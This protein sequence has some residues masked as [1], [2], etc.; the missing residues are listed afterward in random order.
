[1]LTTDV[2]V[3]ADASSVLT[4]HMEI[5]AGNDAGAL[6]IGQT[7]IP[8][9]SAA[10][11][12]AVVEAHTLKPDGKTLPV[13][14]T[15]IYDQ[16]LPGQSAG[17]ITGLR[18]KLIVFPQFA[19]GDTA[20]YTIKLTTKRPNFDN[21]FVYGEIFPRTTAYDEV[22]Q[23]ITAPKNFPL[24]V[25]SHDVQTGR[26]EN[27]ADVTYSWH[28]SAPKPVTEQAP[29]FSPLD[30]IPRFFASSFKDYARLG[31]AYAALTEPK[32]VVT[33]KI[34]ALADEIT[35]GASD[36]RAQT[37]KLYEWV[38]RH[39][40]YVAIELG[41]GS[42]TP[43]DVD[44]ILT[45]G[46]GDCKDHDILL[47]ALLKA[48]SIEAQSIL[49]NGDANYA[50]TD[51]PTFTTLNH[52]ITFVPQFNLYLDSSAAMAPF[53]ILPMQE[54]GKPMVAATAASTGL[55]RMPVLPPGMAK[56]TIKTV[57][58]LDKNGVMS[59]TSTTTASG[60]YAI[61]LQQI[62][63]G[64]QALGPTA[65]AKLLTA[66]GYSNASGSF[67]PNSPTGL[68]PDYTIAGTF[69][70]SGWADAL[71]GKN[72]FLIPSGLRLFGLAGDNVMGPFDPGNMKP[73]EPTVC[74][75]AQQSEDF[76]LTA[77]PGYQFMGLPNET[78][79]ETPNLLFVAH[80]SLAGDTM[81][82]HRDFT[83]KIDQPICTGTVR[84]QTAAALKN[85]AESFVETIS[86]AER[87]GKGVD[88]ATSTAQSFY[89]SGFSHFNEGHYELAI[90][91]F[92]KAIAV[93]PDDF[94][95]Y[96]TRGTS[97]SRLGQYARAIED[98][99]QAIK[100]EKDNAADYVLRAQAHESLGQHDPAIADYGR[101]IALEPD[102]V[103]SYV[104]RGTIYLSLGQKAP[105]IA[106]FE[107]V[108]ALAPDGPEARGA[109]YGRG[110]AQIVNKPDLAVADLDKAIALAPDDAI[111]YG[112]RGAAKANLHQYAAAIADFDKALALR[113]NDFDAISDRAHVRLRTQ[114]YKLAITDYS[115]ALALKPDDA[116]VLNGRG[117]AHLQ[118]GD[119]KAAI[120]DYDKLI[121]QKPDLSSAFL[122]RGDA[123]NKLGLKKEGERDIATAIKLDP[124]LAK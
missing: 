98:F 70:S 16:P 100:L 31:Q 109:Y 67:A 91:D 88:A 19:A 97:Y 46:Y 112:Q 92:D 106:D 105:A 116:E 87:S 26:R 25:E 96:S 74:F 122:Y 72:G 22:R 71:S 114:E 99:D 36:P 39:I 24:Y 108:I 115:K 104:D 61:T 51:I 34:R 83:S 85:I 40:R 4:T 2:Q 101:A 9:D 15:A 89:N 60:P 75:S 49:I 66:L 45:N 27:G 121:A 111:A 57:A 3:A 21:Q 38:N 17:M 33:P 79:I 110:W 6:Q 102:N 30:H 64:I 55:G 1:M 78:R 107:K 86:F 23:T 13:D 5:R 120:A 7:N 119:Y 50:M 118:V 48:K 37:Q 29:T 28:Y 73:G 20:V 68:S 59:G 65:A 54:Y 80:W 14:A 123:K 8:Y 41:T 103:R 12:I 10:Q 32:R 44:A 117:F 94:Y 35:T 47:Q 62:G 77:P 90:A 76:S 53:G 84:T 58:T 52:V 82:V 43:H 42:F 11:E 56:T 113:P 63:L 69:R 124:S 93:K 81:S 95:S 18:A